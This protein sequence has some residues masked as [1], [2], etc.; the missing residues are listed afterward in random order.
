MKKPIRFKND[1]GLTLRGFLCEP[2]RY[3]TAIIFLHGFPSHCRGF[4]ASR[5]SE[6]LGKKYLF[7]TF[8][9]SHTDSSEGKFEDKLISKEVKDIKYAIDFMKNNYQ[10]KKLILIGHSTGAID[11]ALYAYKDK[12]IGKLVLMGAESDLKKAVNY[13][14]TPLQVRDFWTK[15]FIKYNQL[16]KWYYEKKLKKAYYD[17]FFK[18]DVLGSLRKYKKPL[19]I[20]HGEKDEYIPV[21]KDPQELFQA[22]NKPKR[23]VIIK[24]ADHRFTKP[25]HFRKLI[26]TICSF[27]EKES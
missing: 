12:R 7:L 1:K 18:L 3:D 14:F 5:L 27:I 22:A 13:D 19:L 15:G 17:E 4:T 16:G 24:D 23:L 6:A 2:K 11:A 9:F 10:F 20:V 21:N 26:K 8:D 25:L